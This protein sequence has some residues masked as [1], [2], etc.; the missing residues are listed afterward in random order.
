MYLKVDYGTRWVCFR[1]YPSDFILSNILDLNPQDSLKHMHKHI[2]INLGWVL[3]GKPVLYAVM[4]GT[5]GSSGAPL[6]C[7]CLENPM[8]GGAWWAAVH[9]VAESRTRLSNFTFTFHFHALEKEMATHSSVLSWRIPGTG[10]P[11][12]LPSMGSHR[13]GQDWS[14]L[15]AAVAAGHG[16]NLDVHW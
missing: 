10:E 5:K 14:D 1:L 13:V 3:L 8:D 2:V 11:G 15:A 9:G 12:G 16:S 7:S 4:G 6:Q